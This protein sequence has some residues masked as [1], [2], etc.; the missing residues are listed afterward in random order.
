MTTTQTRPTIPASQ[1]RLNAAQRASRDE[2]RRGLTTLR[3]GLYARALK[4][5]RSPA[6][7]DD[8][9]Q[10]TMVR[11]LRFA[12]QYRAGTNLKAWVFQVLMSVFLTGCRRQK[13]ERKALDHL[14]KDPCAWVKRDAP[15]VMRSLSAR[16]AR[17]L[18]SLP[19][20]YRSAVQLVDIDDLSYR[21]AAERL[22]VPVGTIMSRLHRGRKILAAELTDQ[23]NRPQTVADC[24]PMAA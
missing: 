23:A 16:P 7:A 18:A 12:T 15:N 21:E 19:D 24:P 10:D 20:G 6:M 4:L 14:T 13:L 2:V 8:I 17:A 3:S 9:V 1:T 5:S 11:A 22:G